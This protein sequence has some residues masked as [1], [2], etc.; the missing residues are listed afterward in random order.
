METPAVPALLIGALFVEK[1]LVTQEQLELALEEQRSTGNRLG[2]ILVERFEVSRLDLASA[3]AEQWAE[4][5]RQ[6]G[7]PQQMSENRSPEPESTSHPAREEWAPRQDEPELDAATKR[8]IGEIFVERGLI[9]ASDLEEALEEQRTSGQ[10]LGEILVSR[11]N[12]SRLELASALADQWASF[13]KLRPPTTTSNGISEV[14]M[15]TPEVTQSVSAEAAVSASEVA[16]LRDRLDRID[17]ELQRLASVSPEWRQSIDELSSSVDERLAAAEQSSAQEADARLGLRADVASL[18][19]RVDELTQAVSATEEPAIGDLPERVDSLAMAIEAH[20]TRVG[21][22]AQ[23]HVAGVEELR[24]S[25]A[26][27]AERIAES[28]ARDD[29]RASLGEIADA[30]HRRIDSVESTAGSASR[31]ATD[32]LR[33]ELGEIAAHFREQFDRVDAELASRADGGDTGY[34]TETIDRLS[35]RLETL[36]AAQ[37]ESRAGIDGV[38]GQIA[39]LGSSSEGWRDEVE[40]LGVRLDAVSVQTADHESRQAEH[41]SRLDLLADE[42]M[43]RLGQQDRQI[44][45]HFSRL[46][47][48]RAGGPSAAQVADELSARLDASEALA[49]DAHS[50]LDDRITALD[51]RLES[52]LAHS[53]AAV[54]SLRRE[55]DDAVAGSLQPGSTE[56]VERVLAEQGAVLGALRAE[57]REHEERLKEGLAKRKADA[58]AIASRLED[59]ESIVS[60]S[61][62]GRHDAGDS[63]EDVARLDRTNRDLADRLAKLEK[64]QAKRSDVRELREALQRVEEHLSAE[65]AKEDIRVRAIEEALRDGLASLGGRLSETGGAYFQAGDALRRSIEQLGSA[66]RIADHELAA[67]DREEPVPVSAASFL[68]FAPTADGYRIVEVDGVPPATGDTVDVPDCELR[69]VAARVGPS[70]LP[71]D[72][73]VCAYLEVST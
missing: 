37:E 38:A 60:G 53:S 20:E 69:L 31:G 23:Q 12:L 64:A 17:L 54:D 40:Q 1:G 8:P 44:E 36:A 27:L 56:R 67:A 15:P 59:I 48:L 71:F 19:S 10:R 50:S 73:R 42:V 21:E 16:S 24:A 68:A 30:V 55:L 43:Q 33:A 65:E 11:G 58:A 3:L 39:G 6:G 51:Q 22:L 14:V 66:I 13:Q 47:E 26:S 72:R 7:S 2:E 35:Q 25:L 41:G 46:E 61:Q 5:E 28:A 4:Y 63:A 32:D 62:F 49:A 9:S 70:P 57:L 18:T 29:W 45:Q 52:S 34:L